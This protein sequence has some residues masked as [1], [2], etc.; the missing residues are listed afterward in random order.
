MYDELM[1]RTSDDPTGPQT[2]YS[3]NVML[4]IALCFRPIRQ[5]MS[6]NALKISLI[7]HALKI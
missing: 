1:L 7:V 2:L 5:C 4:V 6:Q 3:I